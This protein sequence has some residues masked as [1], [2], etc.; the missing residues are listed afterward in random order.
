MN[1]NYV[2]GV[3]SPNS[4]EFVWDEFMND[5]RPDC[6]FCKQE[7]EKECDA[8]SLDFSGRGIWI[9]LIST[10]EKTE[11]TLFW[12][13]ETKEGL[14]INPNAEWVARYNPEYNTI[15]IIKSNWA[16]HCHK[17]SPCYPGQ[18]DLDTPGDLC[19]AYAPPP[20]VIGDEGNQELKERI[21]KI[22][23]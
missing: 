3:I 2:T 9:G 13:E 7:S 11:D 17:C 5:C 4:M 20:E 18:G 23:G 19:C 12:N 15:Q 16:T 14:M 1:H 22:G 6:L 8:C 10:E 21:F